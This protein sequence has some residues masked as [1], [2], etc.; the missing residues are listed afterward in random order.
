[1]RTRAEDRLPRGLMPHSEYRCEAC[2]FQTKDRNSAMAHKRQTGHPFA[3][4]WFLN[5]LRSK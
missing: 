1:M 2:S 3:E 5:K 4:W